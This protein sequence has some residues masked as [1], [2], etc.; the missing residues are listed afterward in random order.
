VNAV[1]GATLALLVTT[2]VLLLLPPA[3]VLD[4]PVPDPLSGAPPPERSLLRRLR[5]PLTLMGAAGGW[6][7]VGGRPGL[8]AGALAAGAVWW[9][10]GRAEDPAAVRRRAQLVDDLP[11]GVDL[12]GSCLEAGAAPEAALLVVSR[13]VGGPVGEELLAIYHRLQV[14]VDRR[15]VWRDVAAHPQL[16]PLGR[17]VGRAHETGAPIGVAVHRLSEELRARAR[18]EV[19]ER[20]RSMEVRASAP[21]GLCLLPAFV[22]LGVVPMV[23]GVFASMELFG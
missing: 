19:D 3:A 15:Q 18:A 9:V 13:A 20:A 8:L 23:V 14:G 12:L 22:L 2:T 11:T 16:G 10:L 21:L 1:L 7:L 6:S 17:A 5:P 4:D